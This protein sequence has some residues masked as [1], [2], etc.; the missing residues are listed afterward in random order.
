MSDHQKKLSTKKS[1][2]TAEYVVCRD[3]WDSTVSGLY[4]QSVDRQLCPFL[5]RK[6]TRGH[7]EF[8]SRP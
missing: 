3:K 6:M 4:E 5:L 1:T 2:E 7:L 8:L